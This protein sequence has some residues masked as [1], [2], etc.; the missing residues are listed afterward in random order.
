MTWRDA[1]LPAS[2]LLVFGPALSALA[3]VWSS[4]DYYSHGVRVPLVSPR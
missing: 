3:G 2:L 4:V 1:W